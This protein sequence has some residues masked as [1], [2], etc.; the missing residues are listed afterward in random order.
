[1]TYNPLEKASTSLNSEK[2]C[3]ERKTCPDTIRDDFETL[4]KHWIRRIDGA[5]RISVHDSILEL[6]MGPTEALYYS[7]AEVSDGSFDNLCWRLGSIEFK[8]RLETDHYG[9]AGLG[10]W[11]HSMVVDKSFPVWFIYLRSLSTKY[12]LNGFFA[13]YGRVF[14][15][16]KWFAGPPLTVRLAVRIASR[17]LPIRILG[18]KPRKP[19]LDLHNWHTYRIRA[20]GEH[21]VFEIDGEAIGR[22][23][24]TVEPLFRIDM[25]IDN[26]VFTPLR[27]DYARVYRHVT[28]E[29][30]SANSLLIDHVVA[31]QPRG[32]QSP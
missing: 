23:K 15:P 9:S 5:G 1:M 19:D 7:N 4:D 13:Q 18:L 14:I 17:L 27:G 11:N 2:T 29:D 16:I 25:W 20:V 30:R 21:I 10:Y 22:I 8:A 26:S 28:H 6:S 32:Q 24:R 31:S 12:P 3:K